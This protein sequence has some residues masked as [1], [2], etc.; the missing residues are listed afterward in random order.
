MMN[1]SNEDVEVSTLLDKLKH[2]REQLKVNM[3]IVK[4]KY[5]HI[6]KLEN[7]KRKIV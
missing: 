7:R 1:L 2:V 6:K 4:D 3:Y 5:C